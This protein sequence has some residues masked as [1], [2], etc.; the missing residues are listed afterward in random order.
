MPF[1]AHTNDAVTGKLYQFNGRFTVESH[2]PGVWNDTTKEVS[3]NP[4]P[5]GGAGGLSK[6]Y[7]S[8][9][10]PCFGARNQ[11]PSMCNDGIVGG[12]YRLICARKPEVHG[13]HDSLRVNQ[14]TM[15]T[16]LGGLIGVWTAWFQTELRRI[17]SSEVRDVDRLRSH[18]T[19]APH[20]K[21]KLR[22]KAERDIYFSGKKFHKT[23]VKR[24]RYKLKPHELLACG[25]YPRA[26]GDLTCPGSTLG[27]YLMD[28]VKAV[29]ALPFVIGNAS[30]RFIK[31]PDIGVLREVFHCLLYAPG[32]YF[33]FFS[34]DSCIGVDCLDG[35]LVANLDI[36]A[37]DGSNF[38][39]VFDCLRKAMDVDARYSSDIAGIFAQ[40][41]LPFIV[42][43]VD[44]AQRIVFK[45]LGQVLYSGSV[46]TTSINNMANTL[47]FLSIVRK[48]GGVRWTKQDTARIIKE[49]A[50]E[51]GFILKVEI[52]KSHA[53]L[54]FLKHSPAFVDGEIVPYL[55]LGVW[56]RSFG[57]CVGDLPV[58]KGSEKKDK[59]SKLYSSR[60]AAYNSDVVKSRVHAGKHV[61][62]KAFQH[63]IID[64]TLDTKFDDEA[65]LSTN[66]CD[67]II[68]VEEL[69]LR[70]GVTCAAIEE[71]GILISGMDT[72]QKITSDTIDLIFAKDYGYDL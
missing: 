57:T 14:Y 50:E 3:F 12:I 67:T 44:Y 48:L 15:Y 70:Y 49:A 9:F 72:R 6:H 54:Q 47:I 35:R 53:D 60:A 38:D 40:C 23:R 22:I 66:G 18:W 7:R 10:G 8:V 13:L 2:S 32:L 46:L 58:V 33:V 28:T 52:C 65:T 31:C 59:S 64:E 62:Q 11:M 24:V 1:K 26:I 63:F 39:P 25:K 55:N 21:R 41:L 68:P 20:V 43:S 71:L 36:S 16:R 17:W 29:F 69:A 27:G 19:L 34:D 61:I 4:V 5:P 42:H 56:L 30:C 45:P 51:V 37:C